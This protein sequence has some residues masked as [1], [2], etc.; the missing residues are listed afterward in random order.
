MPLNKPNQTKLKK[1]KSKPTF[2]YEKNRG[3]LKDYLKV[4][5]MNNKAV[6]VE[7]PGFTYKNIV[8]CTFWYA[9]T[10]SLGINYIRHHLSW[11]K[12]EISWN[13][14]VSDINGEFNQSNHGNQTSTWNGHFSNSCSVDSECNR[15]Y[16]TNSQRSPTAY[17]NY[18][19]DKCDNMFANFCLNCHG[20][21]VTKL[22]SKTTTK[23]SP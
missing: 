5:G 10:T 21:I 12:P 7:W 22:V 2:R 13:E 20:A 11:Q 9:Y 6:L 16:L 14:M 3:P 4:H 23:A 1:A 17:R 8:N 15:N 18:A 19:L